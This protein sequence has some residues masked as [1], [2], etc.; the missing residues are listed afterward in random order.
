MKKRYIFLFTLAAALVIQSCSYFKGSDAIIAGQVIESGSGN[1]IENAVVEIVSPD[2]MTNTARTDSAGN[3]SMDVDINTTNK[4]AVSISLEITKQGYESTTSDFKL[5]SN[6][7]VDD[8]LIKLRSSDSNEGNEEDETDDNIGGES[9]G[10]ASLELLSISSSSI[11]IRSTGGDEESKFTFVVKDSAGRAVDQGYNVNF[12]I[13]RGPDGGERINPGIGITNSEGR[14]SSAIAS[15]DSAGVIKMQAIISRPD[16]GITVRSTPVLVAVGNGFP[17][18]ENFRI[19]PVYK[20]FEAWNIIAS[21]ESTVKPNI[22]VASLGDYNNNPVLPGTVIDFT[23]SAGIITASAVT[24]E[25]GV[26]IV[27]LR[28]DGSTPRNHPDGVGFATVTARTVDSNDNYI[29]ESTNVLFTSRDPQISIS[30]AVIDIPAN[31]TQNFSMTIIDTNNYPI[32]AGSK[33]AVT[34]SEGLSNT[35]GSETLGDFVKR[36]PGKTTFNFGVSDTDD[37]SNNEEDATIKVKVTLPSGETKSVSFSS[38]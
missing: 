18:A 17:E 37:K 10:P 21:S 22:I 15:G 7:N 36:G 13:I 27:E 1:A 33:I 24:D 35:F 5:T 30:P 25:S 6:N 32:A 9:G 3:F 34:T 20:N 26:A 28:P 4:E 14:V 31:G 38:S 12:S 29:T 19:A 16:V 2:N 8:L 11:A 23:T